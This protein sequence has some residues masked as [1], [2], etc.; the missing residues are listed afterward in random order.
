MLWGNFPLYRILAEQ[1][2]Y[3]FQKKGNLYCSKPSYANNGYENKLFLI[4]QNV[5]CLNDI[6]SSY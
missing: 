5:S 6:S 2:W 1:D 4:V 3:E